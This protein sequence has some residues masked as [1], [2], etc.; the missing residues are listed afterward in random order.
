MTSLAYHGNLDGGGGAQGNSKSVS[1]QKGGRKGYTSY[2]T[3][4][5]RRGSFV[6]ATTLETS[7]SFEEDWV[8]RAEEM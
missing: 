8:E 3:I 5:I 1:C 4:R 2:N 7:F 6:P